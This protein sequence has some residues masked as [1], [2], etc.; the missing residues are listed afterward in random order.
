M[1][2]SKYLQLHT[3]PIPALHYY[4]SDFLPFD[5]GLFDLSAIR[6]LWTSDVCF[7]SGNGSTSPC[8]PYPMFSE[9]IWIISFE[10]RPSF[11]VLCI[12]Q[13]TVNEWLNCRFLRTM[14]A[15]F[16]EKK[17]FCI[18]RVVFLIIIFTIMSRPEVKN[19]IKLFLKD[20]RTNTI[21]VLNIGE[22]LKEE[23][24]LNILFSLWEIGLM[25]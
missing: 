4:S 24:S 23:M 16:V 21:N 22:P 2:Q 19:T 15:A 7:L 5:A 13:V 20:L 18:K 9:K 3:A 10:F 25:K 14:P 11:N 6:M 17:D 8:I 12:F 1:P